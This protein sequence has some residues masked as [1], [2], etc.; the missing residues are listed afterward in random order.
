MLLILSLLAGAIVGVGTVLIVEQHDQSMKDADEV[1]SLLG[2]PVL[3]TV[4]RVEELERQH[5]RP[6][7]GSATAA[8]LPAPREGGLLH[9]L[10][11][12]SP[13]GLEFRRMY[14]NIAR[15]RQRALPKTLLITSATRGEGKS[16]TTAC[17]AITLARELRE[18]LPGGF[19]LRNPVLHR[20]L[21][22]PG[23]SWGLARSPTAQLRRALHPRHGAAASTPAR[24]AAG[25]PPAS[26]WIPKGRVVHR[27]SDRPLPAGADRFRAQPGGA[28]FLIRG[29]RWTALYVI[30][31]GNR[32]ARPPL[33]CACSGRQG[34]AAVG[35]LLNDVEEI[36]RITTATGQLIGY[37]AGQG[38]DRDPAAPRRAVRRK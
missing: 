36:L 33:R 8:G 24:R 21:G 20:A 35:V 5:R 19:D 23:S 29:A 2:L 12:E 28:G 25:V 27:G 18:K 6:K 34:Q 32:C 37:T 13:L 17:L 9:R 31:T 30:K 7:G 14:L 11:V 3:G 10:K 38:G 15:A 16:T 22:L 26:W 4:P 1:E